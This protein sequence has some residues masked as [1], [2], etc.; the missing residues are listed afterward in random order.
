MIINGWENK[1]GGTFPSFFSKYSMPCK[2]II[3]SASHLRIAYNSFHNEKLQ[4]IL[5]RENI[6]SG[7]SFV[8][9]LGNTVQTKTEKF[10]IKNSMSAW[11]DRKLRKQLLGINHWKIVFLCVQWAFKVLWRLFFFFPSDV[12]WV[13]FGFQLLVPVLQS[14]LPWQTFSPRQR[15]CEG[16]SSLHKT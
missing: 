14:V 2:F 3:F 12:F 8:Y 10:L 11:K 5:Q 6:F 1:R 13:S 9:S 15:S 4:T 7:C 16:F